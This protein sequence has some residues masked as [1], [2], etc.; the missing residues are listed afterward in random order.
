M[1]TKFTR[2]RDSSAGMD[3][4]RR[5]SNGEL[6][7]PPSAKDVEEVK[8]EITENCEELIEVGARIRPLLVDGVQIGWVRGI[9]LQE[10]RILK[11]WVRDPQDYVALTLQNATTFS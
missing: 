8:G 5:I 4:M 3:I 9:H 2:G 11:R 6:R 10:R 7:P 1:P